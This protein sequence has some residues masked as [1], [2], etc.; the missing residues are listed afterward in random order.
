M[1]SVLLPAAVA[2]IASGTLLAAA[3]NDT[4]Q[5]GCYDVTGVAQS[6][7][8]GVQDGRY[9]RDAAAAA[10]AL[11]KIGAGAAGFDFSKIANNG[12]VLGAGAALGP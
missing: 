3:L 2:A 6:C 10:G 8:S 1:L 5:T 12:T 7:A 9:G 4:G 11:T